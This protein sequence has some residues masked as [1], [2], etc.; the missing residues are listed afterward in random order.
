MALKAFL[1]KKIWK[2]TQWSLPWNPTL[3]PGCTLHPASDAENRPFQP[4]YERIWLSQPYVL[5]FNT[6]GSTAH[7]VPPL[8][9]SLRM[10]PSIFPQEDMKMVLSLLLL[11][12]NIVLHGYCYNKSLF[13]Y[14]SFW[15]DT[16]FP[17]GSLGSGWWRKWVEIHCHLPRSFL[18]KK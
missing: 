18:V 2:H 16:N 17:N 14:I 10:E 7:T 8:A 6:K 13:G 15:I 1:K 5:P 3:W 11:L 4:R 9:F 12:H